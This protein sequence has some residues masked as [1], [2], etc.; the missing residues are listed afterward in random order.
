M[1]DERVELVADGLR[2]GAAWWAIVGV[3]YGVLFALD[4]GVVPGAVAS[5]LLLAAGFV[6][7]RAAGLIP[8]PAEALDPVA[9]F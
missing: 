3:V 2:A 1:R 5:A 8:T 7:R 6:T 4:S 9:L